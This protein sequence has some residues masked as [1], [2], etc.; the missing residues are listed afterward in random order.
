MNYLNKL[1]S[2]V[3]AILLTTPLVA[4]QTRTAEEEAAY[5]KTINQRAEKIV[6]TLS[7]TD[8]G[9]AA[10]V[11]NI[12]AKQYRSLSEIQ[13]ASDGR[14]KL[15]EQQ[16]AQD[17][18]KKKELTKAIEDET[19]T[20][21]DKLHADYLSALS[22]ELTSEQVES[23]KNGMTYGVLP[24][25]YAGYLDMLPDLNEEQKKQIMTWLVEAREH[26]MD[27]GSS[28]KKHWWFGK[29]KGRI[30]NYLSSAGYDMKKAGEEWEKRRKA[31]AEKS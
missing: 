27:A 22:V 10:R 19:T 9:K 29:Y 2:L 8:A 7:I 14:I 31:R 21:L 23:V 3:L 30:N 6:K 5:T 15:A 13:D 11:Q 24:I 18:E 20:R 28:E 25:T 1:A 26:A 17:G 16:A 4:Q 12:I